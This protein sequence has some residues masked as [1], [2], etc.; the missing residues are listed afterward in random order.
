MTGHFEGKFI[1]GPGIGM[2]KRKAVD[3][4]KSSQPC[5]AISAK[6]QPDSPSFRKFTRKEGINKDSPA[7]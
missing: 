4:S 5:S 7:A 2:Q 1:E 3:C 6:S